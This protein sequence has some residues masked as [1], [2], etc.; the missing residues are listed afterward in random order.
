MSTSAGSRTIPSS[1]TRV[2]SS[3]IGRNNRSV[4][5]SSAIARSAGLVL[6]DDRQDRRVGLRLRPFAVADPELHDREFL[7]RGAGLE[8]LLQDRRGRPLRSG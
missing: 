5:S 3:S 8:H 6:G 1:R 4:I 2:A 7:P